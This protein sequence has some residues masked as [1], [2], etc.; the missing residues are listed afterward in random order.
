MFSKTH[1]YTYQPPF[2]G[3]VHKLSFASV[4]MDVLT[5]DFMD[6]LLIQNQDLNYLWKDDRNMI[7]EIWA[8]DLKTI[9]Y[10]CSVLKN[11]EN[12]WSV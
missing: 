4:Q 1:R 12:E 8:N 6:Y 10:L 2:Y 11:V 9:R 7:L 5:E 3:M